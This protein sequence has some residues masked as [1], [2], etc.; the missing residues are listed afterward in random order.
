[1]PEPER[2]RIVYVTADGSQWMRVD[3]PF[4]L[5]TPPTFLLH[6]PLIGPVEFFD[7]ESYNLSVPEEA[8]RK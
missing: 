5:I 1:M 6:K 2:T 8:K 4:G 7:A 3:V